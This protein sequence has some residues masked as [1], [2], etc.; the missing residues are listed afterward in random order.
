MAS[1]SFAF[2]PL[3][4]QTVLC[5]VHSQIRYVGHGLQLEDTSCKTS[6]QGT[7]H[8][9]SGCRA[10]T[11][12]MVLFTVLT[13][14]NVWLIV[15]LQGMTGQGWVWLGSD[16]V[17]ATP[18]PNHTKA[19]EAMRGSVGIMPKGMCHRSAAPVFYYKMLYCISV[20]YRPCYTEVEQQNR[21]EGEMTQKS[22]PA[23]EKLAQKVGRRE[24]HP[25]SF[26]LS[27]AI[28]ACH[29]GAEKGGRPGFA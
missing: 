21:E 22:K 16:G 14:N 15:A 17:L 5:H 25:C 10:R 7:Q 4:S 29:A 27:M 26:P 8:L 28:I 19:A 12:A 9:Q 20:Y 2:D 6:C 1:L 18:P 23:R 11:P 3:S 13:G 24:I